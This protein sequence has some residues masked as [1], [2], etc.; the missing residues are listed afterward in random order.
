MLDPKS[1][2]C[3]TRPKDESCRSIQK[4]IRRLE[5]NL[6]NVR[7][8]SLEIFNETDHFASEKKINNPSFR[9]LMRLFDR[10]K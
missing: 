2:Q 9:I 5:T 6:K 7:Q 4:K 3:Q 1:D 10:L 8:N